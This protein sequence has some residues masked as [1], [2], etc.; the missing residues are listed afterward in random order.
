[1]KLFTQIKH[2][3]NNLG[4]EKRSVI[5]YALSNVLQKGVIFLTTPIITRLLTT[6][7]YGI[8]SVF[9]SWRDIFIIFATLNLYQGVFT[10]I[11]VDDRE[12][13][14]ECTS[15]I[16]G[17]GWV[18]TAVFAIIYLFFH[19]TI[20]RILNQD[21]LSM[22]SLILYFFFFPAFSL[23]CTKQRVNY[24]Y[25]LMVLVTIIISVLTPIT[26]IILL[27]LTNLR[28][29]AAI[30]GSMV[31]YIIGGLFFSIL[32]IYKGKKIYDKSRWLFAIKYNVP[33]IPHYLSMIVLS[34]SD[35]IM[36]DHF[37]GEEKAGIYSLAYQ[38]SSMMN[39]LYIAINN[40]FVPRSY[41]LLKRF[42]IKILKK[43]TE[44][45]LIVMGGLTLCAILV[46]PDLVGFMG[47]SKYKEA[48]YI[49]PP[50]CTA[51]F[52]TFCYSF[53]NNIEFYYAKTK[54]VMIA[55]TVSAISNIVLNWIFI[56][57]YG[58]IA[59]GYTTLASYFLL[60]LMHYIFS[61][62]ISVNQFGKDIYDWKRLLLVVL[63]VI[64]CAGILLVVY[65]FTLIRY[66][67]VLVAAIIIVFNRKRILR[68]MKKE[69]K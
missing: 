38:I 20:N 18:F 40:S 63:L 22:V 51:L 24:Q 16:Q 59:A 54:N 15:T 23:W 29:D 42:D 67:L 14:E 69:K 66:A 30:I 56:L 21:T 8:Y 34:H 43:E 49:I 58:Y 10:K 9:L 57:K 19:N 33:L 26:S 6:G 35:R 61:H 64:I 17:L 36:I 52:V 62:R 28:A 68:I 25:K 39:I 46:A 31:I 32:N 44:Q 50:V 55:S 47:G 27:Y 60:A 2:K 48:I 11:L 12:R 41:E 4:A 45:L 3:Y 37:C 53:F 65:N 1:M 13:Q 7:E 5:W